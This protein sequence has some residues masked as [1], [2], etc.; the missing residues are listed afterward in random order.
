LTLLSQIL[1]DPI[2]DLPVL[3]AERADPVA[4]QPLQDLIQSVRVNSFAM[5]SL[6]SLS[7]PLSVPPRA[8][9]ATKRTQDSPRHSIV[10]ILAW[11]HLFIARGNLTLRR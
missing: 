5:F 10:N 9:L 3:F 11:G 1:A 7:D 2:E 8:D 4:M 6:E